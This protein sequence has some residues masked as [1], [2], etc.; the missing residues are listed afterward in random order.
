MNVNKPFRFVLWMSYA[1]LII[2]LPHY[3][4]LALQL[5]V[6]W[7][8]ILHYVLFDDGFV[9]MC[10]N[11]YI[12]SQCNG[13]IELCIFALMPFRLGAEHVCRKLVLKT[14]EKHSDCLTNP[15]ILP[16]IGPE[17]VDIIVLN[18][19]NSKTW[20]ILARLKTLKKFKNQNTG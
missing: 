11:Q 15:V 6:F 8:E 3:L 19:Q 16:N 10:S 12:L 5:I 2:K 7:L 14:L 1:S 18:L 13:F 9:S 17:R 20:D 4:P